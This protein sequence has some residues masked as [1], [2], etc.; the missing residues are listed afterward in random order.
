MTDR[1]LNER[2]AKALGWTEIRYHHDGSVDGYAPGATIHVKFSPATSVDELRKWVLP[3]IV[4][5]KKYSAW[6]YLVLDIID[7]SSELKS[8]IERA[9][10]EDP[11]AT[12]GEE[13]LLL[14]SAMSMTMPPP[15]LLAAA[16]LEVLEADNA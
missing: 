14:L 10:K 6:Y 2:I 11:A 3:E 7:D 5:R 15:A 8:Y 13:V 12:C 4:K 9:A 1:Q 16:A